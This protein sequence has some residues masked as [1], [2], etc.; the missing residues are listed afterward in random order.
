[1]LQFVSFPFR[2]ILTLLVSLFC[3]LLHQW[4]DSETEINPVIVSMYDLFPFCSPPLKPFPFMYLP[5]L[6]DVCLHMP[7]FNSPVLSYKACTLW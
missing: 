2:L 4:F 1:M 6:T 3:I 7:P 5:S